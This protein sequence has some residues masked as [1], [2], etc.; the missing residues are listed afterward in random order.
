[1]HVLATRS[2]FVP[3]GREPFFAKGLAAGFNG[4]L[5]V[6]LHLLVPQVEPALRWHLQR[7]GVNTIRF[8]CGGYQ[9]ERDLNQL[10]AMPEARD[11]L[12]ERIHFAL[13]ALLTSRFGA[14]LRNDLAH[15]LIEAGVCYSVI[16]LFFWALMLLVCVRTLP[17]NDRPARDDVPPEA[18]ESA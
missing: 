10:L 4:E 1:M 12:G 9:E 8:N 16:V 7:L 5:M 13:T 18:A 15:G 3:P 17:K 14:N 11:F 6:A 2:W